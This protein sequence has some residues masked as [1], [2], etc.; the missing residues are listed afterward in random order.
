MFTVAT[1][2][3]NGTI[4]LHS[5]EARHLAEAVGRMA[6]A[7]P[8]RR[9]AGSVLTDAR[10]GQSAWSATE[11]RFVV[12][13]SKCGH[14]GVLQRKKGNTLHLHCPACEGP[15]SE[16][17]WGLAGAAIGALLIDVGGLGNI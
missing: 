5:V 13:C 7:S 15:P 2:A 11:A 16:P 1:E 14:D 9:P 6:H 8:R 17:G 12:R 4:T 3:K 10:P